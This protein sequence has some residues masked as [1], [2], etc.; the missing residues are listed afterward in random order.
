MD[1]FIPKLNAN[2]GA[3][4]AGSVLVLRAFVLLSM[5]AISVTTFARAQD[6]LSSTDEKQTTADLSSRRVAQPAGVVESSDKESHKKKAPRETLALQPDAAGRQSGE[7]S[8]AAQKGEWVIAPIPVKSPAIGAGLQW[9]V[10]YVTPFSKDDKV[11]PPS[12]FGVGGLFTSNGSRGLAIGARLYLKE[13][14]Y[15]ISFAGGH[16]SINAEIY[17]V[18][19]LA[20]DRG[21]FVPVNAKGTAFFTESLFRVGK[22]I[23]LGAR[24]QYR[25]LAL[26]IDRQNS[27][28]PDDVVI[29]PPAQLADII[30]VIKDNLFRQKTVAVGPRFQWDTRDNT[31]YPR[32]GVFLD[33]GIDLFAEAIGSKFSYQYYKA[34]FNKYIGLGDHQLVAVRAMGCAAAGDRVPAYDLCLFGFQNDLRGYTAGRYQDRRMFATQA[35]Y[36]FTVPRPGFL[37]RFGLVAFGGVG[38]VGSKFTDIGFSDMLPAGGAG[39]RFRL[40]KRNPI[41]FR[42][43]YGYGKTGGSFIVGVGEAF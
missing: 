15:R 16:A 43:D 36:R 9:A 4:V 23:Y 2:I 21:V 32:R 11:S 39:I 31:F 38:G 41:N 3:R 7:A 8:N 33:S 10:G 17:G 5:L 29:N 34:A 27:D 19:K 24:F 25:N 28:L 12:M 13:D 26:S 40:T 30:A 42:I 35:E 14:K 18:G 1:T 6:R 20:G 22:G 37:G